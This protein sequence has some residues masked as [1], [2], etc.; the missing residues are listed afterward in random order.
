MKMAVFLLVI[1]M[2]CTY[3]HVVGQVRITV[4]D[5]TITYF[6]L[7]KQIKQQTGFTVVFSNNELDKYGKVEAG[8]DNQELDI[9]LN[10]VLAGTRLT[11]IIQD[12][13]IILKCLPDEDQ[14]KSITLKGFV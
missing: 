8:F 4:K 6:D 9:V 12:E 1:T 2:H 13:F 10:K 3:A 11:Y 7:F 5:R 14:K